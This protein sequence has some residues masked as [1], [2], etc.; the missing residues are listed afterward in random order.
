MLFPSGEKVFIAFELPNEEQNREIKKNLALDVI[1]RMNYMT[2]VIC[3]LNFAV[4][5]GKTL[6]HCRPHGC[7]TL[8]RTVS[9][10]QSSTA[11]LNETLAHLLSLLLRLLQT[12][13]MMEK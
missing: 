10:R 11:E 5:N 12:I 6:P 3:P 4:D 7:G 2:E 8:L 13:T 9:T 1:D